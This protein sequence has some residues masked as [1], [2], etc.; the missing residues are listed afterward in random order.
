[1]MLVRHKQRTL[2][3]NGPNGLHPGGQS[4]G[5]K[6]GDDGDLRHGIILFRMTISTHAPFLGGD[7]QD[8]AAN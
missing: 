7:S 6:I 3:D 2:P 1:M 4:N 5:I 8:L